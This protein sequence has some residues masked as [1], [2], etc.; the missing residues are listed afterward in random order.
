MTRQDVRS[1]SELASQLLAHVEPL[2]ARLG[3]VPLATEIQLLKRDLSGMHEVLRVTG[4]RNFLS[5]VTL[6]ESAL[7]CLTWKQYTSTIVDAL[8]EAFTAGIREGTF[9]VKDY[10][11]VR[12]LF[13]QRRISTIPATDLDSLEPEDLEDGQEG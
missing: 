10:D 3:T 12:R 1:R 6:V 4:E 11:A 8:R 7:A 2:S 5:V 9:T 13:A